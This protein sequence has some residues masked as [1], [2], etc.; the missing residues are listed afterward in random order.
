M[1]DDAEGRSKHTEAA[2]DF[3]RIKQHL[4]KKDEELK[5]LDEE[6]REAERK[7]KVVIV[8]AKPWRS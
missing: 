5:Q 3:E 2:D 8:D 4:A 1:S 6:I 7:S